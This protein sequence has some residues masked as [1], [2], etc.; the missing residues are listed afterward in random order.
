M[1][2]G[3]VT[4]A[5]LVAALALPAT[6][7]VSAAPTLR[8]A[9]S[10][11]PVECVGWYHSTVTLLWDWDQL[12]AAPI[13]GNCA[14]RVF[15]VDTAGTPAS[16][17][18]QDGDGLKTRH[19][20]VIRIDRTAPTVD[21]AIPERR[22]DYA[23]WF[24]APVRFSFTG[25]DGTS[26][27]QS[28]TSAT[29]SGP[30]GAGVEVPGTCRDVAGNTTVAAF[31]LN[32]DATPPPAPDAR[33]VPGDRLIRVEWAPLVSTEEVEVVRLGPGAAA[34]L[35]RGAGEDF[36]E[37]GLRNGV[38]HRYRVTA[39]DRAGNTSSKDVTATPTSSPLLAPAQRERLRRP[40]L[41]VWKAVNRASYYNVQLFRRGRKV[42][43]RWPR[44]NR[45]QLRRT[46]QFAGRK[47]RLRPGRYVW[48]VWPGY[49]KR[50]A[51]NYGPAL[52]KRTFFITRSRTF[53]IAGLL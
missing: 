38:L 32:Y 34:L 26:G 27:L 48:Y 15:T 29:Y 4:L 50:A 3:R 46:W 19:T 22:P 18:I 39:I 12:V 53:D 43:S 2:R 24:T 47:Q 14:P 44:T 1:T 25:S 8:Y 20:V 9:C 23:G 41:L 21:E 5:M 30:D 13:A 6:P 40:P 33:A 42:L 51:R 16:C 11:A 17:E 37:R 35:Y 36:V 45:L 28:C 52:G 31:P 7:A 10:P 49:G